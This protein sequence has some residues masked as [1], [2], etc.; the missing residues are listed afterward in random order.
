ME[1]PP[2]C[3]LDPRIAV[4]PSPIDGLGLLA[5]APINHGEIVEMLGGTTL[6]DAQVQARIDGGQRYDG[7]GLGPDRNLSIDPSR[8]RDLRQP[9]LR[10]EPLDAGCRHHQ[11]PS[12]SRYRRRAND[13]LRGVHRNH[14]LVNALSLQQPAVS[15]CSNRQ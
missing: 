4:R 5:A 9:L 7:I 6:T 12:S 11:H 13:R 14:E 1:V 2:A 15:R 10:P 8:A 3:W